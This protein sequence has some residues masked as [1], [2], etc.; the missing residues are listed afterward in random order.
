M[1]KQSQLVFNQAGLNNVALK[2]IKSI[3][4]LHSAS[5]QSLKHSNHSI[6]IHTGHFQHVYLSPKSSGLAN[7]QSK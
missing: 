3:K 5:N 2:A 1:N 6:N 4:Q 7:C